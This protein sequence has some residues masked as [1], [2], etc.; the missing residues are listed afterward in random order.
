MKAMRGHAVALG[1]TPHGLGLR[2]H[3]SNGVEHSH[4]AV[5]DA[6]GA[7]D[8]GG[9]VNVA[10]GVDDLE[11]VRPRPSFFQ[12]HV[13]AAA[14]MVTPRSCSWTIQSMVA[15]PSCT[16]PILCVLPV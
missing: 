12:K 3:A 10:G 1:L 7:L 8:L 9:E 4:G 5:E 14:V 13:V 2:L 6:Q 16:S 11:A 15:A